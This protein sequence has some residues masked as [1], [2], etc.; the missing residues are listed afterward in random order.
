MPSDSRC[1]SVASG[2]ERCSCSPFCV[3]RL[4]WVIIANLASGEGSLSGH[5]HFFDGTFWLIGGISRLTCS[6]FSI[7]S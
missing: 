2:Q 7:E 3:S 1:T 4:D 6:T 5:P